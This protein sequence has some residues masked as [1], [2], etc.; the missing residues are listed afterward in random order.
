MV[1]SSS[2]DRVI[3]RLLPPLTHKNKPPNHSEMS[4]LAVSLFKK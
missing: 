1:S 2:P 4:N 3:A